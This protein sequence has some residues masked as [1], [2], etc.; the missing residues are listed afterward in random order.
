MINEITGQMTLPSKGSI[1]SRKGI[2]IRLKEE[3]LQKC[4]EYIG[5]L[6]FGNSGERPT[7]MTG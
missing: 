6:F 1:K 7:I 5:E 4:K 3:I 2:L